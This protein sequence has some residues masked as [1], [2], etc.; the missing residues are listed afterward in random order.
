MIRFFSL[1]VI[2]SS[3]IFT[4]NIMSEIINA[5]GLNLDISN[6]VLTEKS[7]ETL[8]VNIS[9]ALENGLI[10]KAVRLSDILI[11]YKP[12]EAPMKV[13]LIII[14]AKYSEGGKGRIE[15]YNMIKELK[16]TLDEGNK[17]ELCKFIIEI[18]TKPVKKKTEIEK[19][20]VNS[21]SSE[22]TEYYI[23]NTMDLQWSVN[24]IWLLKDLN[25]ELFTEAKKILIEELD[26]EREF[27]LDF[28]SQS[29]PQI[30]LERANDE[31]VASA[32]GWRMGDIVPGKLAHLIDKKLNLTGFSIC[33]GHPITFNKLSSII[34]GLVSF[35]EPEIIKVQT[36]SEEGWT[37]YRS[38]ARCNA[39]LKISI[40]ELLIKYGADPHAFKPFVP[41]API[42]EKE[43]EKE[44]TELEENG[45]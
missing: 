11:K 26:K 17:N 15:A 8:I 23:E 21:L 3:S 9:Y 39:I 25:E 40:S 30:S 5:E 31:A 45:I 35:S 32:I 14:K 22:T 18:A 4:I 38:I 12:K 1:F 34:K 7:M 10:D 24:L 36:Y 43:K 2:L 20:S 27:S 29:T 42:I 19:M 28:I 37:I 13:N 16:T 6:S 33:I 41:K 44:E